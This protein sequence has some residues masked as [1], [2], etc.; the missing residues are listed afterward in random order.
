MFLSRTVRLQSFEWSFLR[1]KIK[2]F[3]FKF[4]NSLPVLRPCFPQKS[5][6]HMDVF[7]VL[8]IWLCNHCFKKIHM[9]DCRQMVLCSNQDIMT[10]CMDFL[11]LVDLPWWWWRG[12]VY[13]WS[14]VY[15]HDEVVVALG[16]NTTTCYMWSFKMSVRGPKTWWL[17]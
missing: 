15:L 4:K 17:V 3:K 14:V 2:I 10:G 1:I 7:L 11:C 12:W 16:H 13:T 6:N 9:S 8:T 5:K